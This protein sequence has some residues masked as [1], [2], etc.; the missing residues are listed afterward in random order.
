MTCSL[1][2][3]SI[4]GYFKRTAWKN[5]TE[6]TKPL[7]LPIFRKLNSD[8]ALGNSKNIPENFSCPNTGHRFSLR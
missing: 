8:S 3:S 6:N 5:K 7:G 4:S 1:E 2:P